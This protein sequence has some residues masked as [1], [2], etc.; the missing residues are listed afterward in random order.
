MPRKSSPSPEPQVITVR[1]ANL[2][3]G[4]AMLLTGFIGGSIAMGQKG[5]LPAWLSLPTIPESNSP[6]APPSPPSPPSVPQAPAAPADTAAQDALI[7]T[8]DADRDHIRGNADA[9]VALIEYSDL[10]CPFCKRVHP[11]L[12]GVIDQDDG[13]QWV[14]R[15]FPLGPHKNAQKASEAVEC[16]GKIGGEGKAWAM[17]ELIFE[18]GPDNTKL[19]ELAAELKLRASAF[20]ECLDTGAFTARVKED[21]A[22]AQEAGV[23]GTPSTFVMHIPSGRVQRVMGA[24]PEADFLQ[25]IAN[26]RK[27]TVPAPTA[28]AAPAAAAQASSRA[29]PTV[30]TVPI[31]VTNWAF[32]PSTFTIKKGDTVKLRF[33]GAEGEHGVS[34][35]GLGITKMV[36]QGQTVEF[37]IPTDKTGTFPFSCNVACGSGHSGMK[38]T[39]TIEE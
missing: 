25:A 17:I 11:T 1:K 10:E 12:Q 2:W 36:A 24:R 33:V 22:P 18:K 6:P 21:M 14:Y 32:T 16:A 35:P 31:R 5:A 30:Y 3:F 20:E 8:V 9:D 27:D 15:H 34:I 19:K 13:V 38:G 26:V 39:I 37:S 28:A 7:P 4:V 29:R 23:N